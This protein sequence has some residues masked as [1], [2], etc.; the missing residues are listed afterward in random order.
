MEAFES[1]S[2]ARLKAGGETLAHSAARFGPAS[3]A[4][5]WLARAT[6][7]RSRCS[8]LAEQRWL[9]VGVPLLGLRIGGCSGVGVALHVLERPIRRSRH[10][11]SR[12]QRGITFEDVALDDLLA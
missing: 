11:S 6:W 1:T 7:G 8:W 10:S 2:A 5:A 3:T 9:G 12:R 4:S